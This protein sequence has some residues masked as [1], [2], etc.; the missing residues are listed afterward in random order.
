M[1]NLKMNTCLISI[2]IVHRAFLQKCFFRIFPFTHKHIVLQI[3]FFIEDF[4]AVVLLNMSRILTKIFPEN[5]CFC[6]VAND[7]AKPNRTNN[8]PL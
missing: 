1:V 3:I 7:G 5:R 6:A 8:L 4:G 2:L